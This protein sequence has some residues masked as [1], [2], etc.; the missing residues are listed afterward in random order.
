MA[1]GKWPGNEKSRKPLINRITSSDIKASFT[2]IFK[3]GGSLCLKNGRSTEL[4]LKPATA[5]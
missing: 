3:N 1:S 4:T 2:N 5:I